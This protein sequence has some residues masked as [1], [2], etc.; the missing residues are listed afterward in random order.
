MT[1]PLARNPAQVNSSLGGPKDA[2]RGVIF[3]GALQFR[4]IATLRL[5]ASRSAIASGLLLFENGMGSGPG[6]NA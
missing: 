5:L 4:Q 2:A 3:S 6:I 1:F